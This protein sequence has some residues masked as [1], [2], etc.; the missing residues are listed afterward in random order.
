MISVAKPAAQYLT[1]KA[2]IDAAIRRVLTSGNYILG[3]EVASF[4]LAFAQYCH[5]EYAVGVGSGTD[6]LS[7]ALKAFQVDS[8]HEVITVSH[9]AIATVA[10]VLAV[11]A[12]PVLVDVDP[13]YYTM[14]PGAVEL[15]ITKRTKAIIVVHLYG[16]AADMEPLIGLA[17]HHGLIVIE[18]CAHALGGSYKGK[19]LGSFGDAACFSF[20][21]TKNLGAIGEG[22]MVVTSDSII[23]NRVRRLRKY[24]WDEHRQTCDIGV[25]SCLDEIQAAILSAKLPS[26]DADNDRRAILAARYSNRLADLPIIVPHIR[27]ETCHVFH[28]YVIACD[29]RDALMSYLAAAKI[30]TGVHYPLPAHRHDG[31]ASRVRPATELAGTDRLATRILSLPIYPELQEEEV[32]SVIA[33]IVSYYSE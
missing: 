4:E 11:G 24:G 1:H 6:A 32:E 26:L 10:A 20:Y 14:D 19:R 31:Y 3:D 8:A 5:C 12:I 28:Q 16:Q 9:T 18:D 27:P 2:A 33:A 13:L 30:G 23:A 17:K 15:A 7:L 29:E 21:P 22:G 25:N